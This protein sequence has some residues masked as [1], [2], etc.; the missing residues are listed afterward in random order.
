MLNMD[1][2]FILPGIYYCFG[3][4]TKCP[5]APL[6]LVLFYYLSGGFTPRYILTAFQ[7]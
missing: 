4:K 1:G 6:G 3:H 7:A 2:I 5:V